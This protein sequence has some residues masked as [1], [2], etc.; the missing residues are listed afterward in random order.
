MEPG[1]QSE[2]SD[3][4]CP[5]QESRGLWEGPDGLLESAKH[6]REQSKARPF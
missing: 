1:L 5:L 3:P 2:T 6:S 4:L